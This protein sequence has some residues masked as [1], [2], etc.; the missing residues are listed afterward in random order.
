[1]DTRLSERR[2]INNR[3]R[4]T[5]QLRRN[6]IMYL[7]TIVA[8]IG[9]SLIFFGFRAKAQ[10]SD[11]VMYKY[12]KSVVVGNGDTLW[13][14]ANEYGRTGQYDSNRDYIKEV[15]CVNALSS[16]RIMAGQ[17]LILPYYSSEPADSIP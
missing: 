17:Y 5:R 4:R 2:I 11:E 14:Y 13:N 8:A 1:M 10:S 7:I 15:M 16:D 3:I 6:I 9:S 12:Y